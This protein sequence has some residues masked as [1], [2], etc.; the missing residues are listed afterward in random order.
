MAATTQ[1]EDFSA[2]L[3]DTT[4]ADASSTNPVQA[5]SLGKGDFILI[6]GQP[7][8]IVSIAKSKPGKH[9]HAKVNF[10]A[11][12]LLNAKKY[13][14]VHPAHATVSSPIVSLKSY[15]LIH[16]SEGYLSLWDRHAGQTKDDVRVPTEGEMGERLS[17]LWGKG[18]EKDIWVTILRT[19]GKE[20]V[21]GFK[22]VKGVGK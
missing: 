10:E 3:I 6:K 13:E 19:M 7:C 11:L 22:E 5:S 1:N 20:I 18:G 8:K 2:S 21:E 9:G 15:L 4:D 16:I 14:A 12:S 17:A